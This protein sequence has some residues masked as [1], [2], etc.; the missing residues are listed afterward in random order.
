MVDTHGTFSAS[1]IR[2]GYLKYRLVG[3]F[4]D[5]DVRNIKAG[6]IV[7]GTIVTAVF[8]AI[9]LAGGIPSMGISVVAAGI[10]GIIT[11]AITALIT[12]EIDRCNYG[13][14]ATLSF[15]FGV[16]IHYYYKFRY[17]KYWTIFGPRWGVIG[18]TKHPVYTPYLRRVPYLKWIK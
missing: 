17:G 13:K 5:Q 18:V 8:G 12:N 11:T 9:G 10:G 16:R 15:D 4:S 3:Y 1:V 14:G 7:T 6:I 2:T